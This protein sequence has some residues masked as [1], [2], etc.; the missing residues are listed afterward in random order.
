VGQYQYSSSINVGVYISQ[1]L[2]Q[3]SEYLER[4]QLLTQKLQKSYFAHSHRYKNTIVITNWLIVTNYPCLK[5]QWTFSLLTRCWNIGTDP[6]DLYVMLLPRLLGCC[7][8]AIVSF[9]YDKDTVISII[10]KNVVYTSIMHLSN[11]EC[12]R[13]S[14]VCNRENKTAYIVSS[15]WALN[16]QIYWFLFCSWK[17]YGTMHSVGFLNNVWRKETN[18]MLKHNQIL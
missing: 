15:S 12:W 14:W 16:D 6:L 17:P 11:S 1:L 18:R 7:V 10:P 3:H 5:W 8:A 2:I 9:V 4:V 13:K